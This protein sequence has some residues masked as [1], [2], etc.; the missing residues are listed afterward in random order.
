MAR[1]P[2]GLFRATT[3]NQAMAVLLDMPTVPWTTEAFHRSTWETDQVDAFISHSWHSGPWLKCFALCFDYNLG[4]AA[5]ASVATFLLSSMSL[6]L[7]AAGDQSHYAQDALATS[8]WVLPLTVDLP[9]VVFFTLF[10]FGHLVAQEQPTST[11]WLDKACIYQVELDEKQQAIAALPDF[12]KQSAR[13]LVLWDETYFSRLWCNLEIATFARSHPNPGGI[14]ILSR[15][16]AV[17]LLSSLL[18]AWFGVRFVWPWYMTINDTVEQSFVVSYLMTT[19]TAFDFIAHAMVG[20]IP[21]FVCQTPEHTVAA[22]AFTYKARQNNIM[23]EHF[24]NFD[25]R[26]AQ[27]TVSDDRPALY[28]QIARLFDGIDE[29][30]I[31]VEFGAPESFGEPLTSDVAREPSEQVE[32]LRSS[33]RL[34]GIT[35]YPS[36]EECLVMFNEYVRTELCSQIIADLGGPS[37]FRWNLAILSF[38]PHLFFLIEFEYLQCE[39]AGC[40]VLPKLYGLGSITQYWLLVLMLYAYIWVVLLPLSCPGNIWLVNAISPHGGGPLRW[41]L[42]LLVGPFISFCSALAQSIFWGAVSELLMKG[43][44]TL[45]LLVL[46][47]LLAASA[48][49]WKAAFLDPNWTRKL[50]TRACMRCVP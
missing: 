26:N 4:R 34:R 3:L 40:A 39:Q 20:F 9:M 28:D 23:L 42:T 30:P 35:S 5:V 16:M 47:S 22:L 2:P 11:V 8:V 48:L 29:M 14:R 33:P 43:C 21:I 45:P 18:T 41:L 27:C 38:L 37:Q 50:S 6:Y 10:F 46:L 7:S 1:I 31:S 32:L 44:C 13:V 36:Q 12:L 24:S 17:W 15:W 19:R 49:L 25:V